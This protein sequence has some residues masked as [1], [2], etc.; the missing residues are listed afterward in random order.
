MK[1]G[2]GGGVARLIERAMDWH[3]IQGSSN[4]PSGFILQKPGALSICMEKTVRIFLQ[5]EQYDFY[6]N[7]LEW[8]KHVPFT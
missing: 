2:G 7:K 3:P 4:T 6:L 5:K 1:G 8:D